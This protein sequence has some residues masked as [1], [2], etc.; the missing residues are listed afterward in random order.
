LFILSLRGKKVIERDV[1]RTSP[2]VE[3]VNT[4]ETDT[5]VE[6]S[7]NSILSDKVEMYFLQKENEDLK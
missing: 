1:K 4:S 5:I 3:H 7:K 6:L 2:I